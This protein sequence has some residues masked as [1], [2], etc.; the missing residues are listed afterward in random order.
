MDPKARSW[1]ALVVLVAGALQAAEVDSRLL[2]IAAR[3]DYGWMTGDLA[4]ITAA[5]E[6]LAGRDGD[7]WGHYLR[8]YAAFRAAEW[9]LATG[10]PAGDRLD[11]CSAQAEQAFAFDE[12]AVEASILLAA[13]SAMAS[14]E[15]PLRAVLQQR[16]LRQGLEYAA[17]RAPEN[18]RLLLIA[19]LYDP[20]GLIVPRPPAQTLLDAFR[21]DERLDA[22]PSW[23]E[24]EAMTLVAEARLQSGDTRGARD[25]LEQALLI[26]PDYSTARALRRRVAELATAQ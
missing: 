17:E 2:D 23:G 6:A 25:L 15:Q 24:A 18:P 5:D 26:A 22:F 4:L 11:D 13:C 3:I 14:R 10:K 8:S 19:T 16:R 20:D 1:L 12:A 9:A 7:A 21:A